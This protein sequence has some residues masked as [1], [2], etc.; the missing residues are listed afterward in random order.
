MQKKMG[1]DLEDC[2]LILKLTHNVQSRR[3]C[4]YIWHNH[5]KIQKKK[6][7]LN[8]IYSQV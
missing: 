1:M 8:E 2:V 5:L 4:F 7:T 6:K 3:Y